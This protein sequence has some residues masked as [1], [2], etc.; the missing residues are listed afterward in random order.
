MDA[1]DDVSG[2]HQGVPLKRSIQDLAAYFE[3]H[4]VLTTASP[5]TTHSWVTSW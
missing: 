4:A 5:I 3:L 2:V 1:D